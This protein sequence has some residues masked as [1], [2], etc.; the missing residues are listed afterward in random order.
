[1]ADPISSLTP[2]S[3]LNACIDD[4]GDAA[5]T[6]SATPAPAANASPMPAPT[7]GPAICEAPPSAVPALVQRFSK[8]LPALAS[9]APPAGGSSA[10]VPAVGSHRVAAGLL[11]GQI[12][13]GPAHASGE[14]GTVSY[15]SGTDS[16]IQLTGLRGNLT[17]AHGGY[18]LSM[19]REALTAR[20]NLGEHNDDGSLGGNIGVGATLGGIEGTLETPY[21]S[22]TAGSSI[23]VGASGSM[24]VRDGDHDGKPEFCAKFSIPAYTLGAC[25]EQFW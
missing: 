7:N 10:A 5:A 18:S 25:V 15:R 12:D 6:A 19:T 8:P 13:R 17:V 2:N 24:G 20:A 4:D 9:S 16:D 11:K 21:G 1:M 23:S 14:V 22:I 3:P